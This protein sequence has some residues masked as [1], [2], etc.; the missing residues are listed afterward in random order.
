MSS[1]ASKDSQ[2]NEEQKEF[3][4]NM[5]T[6]S[7]TIVQLRSF[8]RGWQHNRWFENYVICDDMSDLIDEMST[9]FLQSV[10]DYLKGASEPRTS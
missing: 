10:E 8:L 9:A 3:V 1:L 2:L 4:R 5:E 7:Q 6:A